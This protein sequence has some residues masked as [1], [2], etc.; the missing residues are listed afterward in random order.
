MRLWRALAPLLALA[1]VAGGI[2]SVAPRV[3]TLANWNAGVGPMLVSAWA[4]AALFAAAA[5]STGARLVRAA[6][7]GRPVDGFWALSFATGAAIFALAH[8][9]GGWVGALGWAWF[10]LLPLA[11][12]AWGWRTVVEVLVGRHEDAPWKLELSLLE[13]VALAFGVVCIGLL[14]LQTITADNVNYDAA[15]YH[16]RAAE[17]YALAGGQVHTPEGD[18]LLS[19]PQTASW[20]YTWA[21]LW[22][23]ASLEDHVRLAFLLELATVLGTLAALPALVRAVCPS[24]PRALTRLSWVAFFFYPS[25]FVYDTGVMGGADH[26]VTLW[27]VTAILAWLHA[28]EAGTL[29]AWALFGVHLAGL[30]AKYSSLYV[31]VP[32]T[33]LVAG[34]WLWR[35]LSARERGRVG[36][37]T[38][39]GPLVTAGLALALTSPY[40][41]RNAI[42][43]HN[44]VYPAATGIFP[45]TP[46]HADAEAWLQNSKESTFWTENGT[47]AHKLQVSAQALFNYQTELNTWGDL[48]QGQPVVGSS[49]FL[50][51]LALPFIRDRKRRLVMLAFIVNAG[52]FV[53]FNTH[54]HQFRYLTILMAP[55]AAGAAAVA[56]SLWRSESLFARAAVLA[57][58]AWHLAAFADMPFRKTHRMANRESTVSVA[59]EYLNRHG[60]RVGR[61]AAWEAI[62]QALPPSAVPL[63]HGSFPHLGL[64]RQSATDVTG[65]QFGINYGR[66][67]SQKEIHAQLRKMGVTHLIWNPGCEQSDSV[68]GEALFLGLATQVTEKKALHGYSVG[69]LPQEPREIGEGILYVG[70]ANLFESGLYTLE[71]LKVPVPPWFHPWPKVQPVAKVQGDWRALLPRASY[72]ALEAD[73]NLG[74]PPVTEFTWMND[75]MGFPRKL[76]HFVRTAGQAQGWGPPQ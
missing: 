9:L 74:D 20:L 70:C 10:V 50:S 60:G 29:R 59:S 24:L 5:L 11:M 4:L 38:A 23:R 33:L 75:Q 8:G 47:T 72:V 66:W 2:A 61:L 13:L 41:L 26:V 73:C 39:L 35:A 34:D 7:R 68:T 40:W 12:L 53:W 65:L 28:R 18:L 52:I 54:Q 55:M 48:T 56:L 63:V 42:W 19:L 21:F 67:G 71:A 44:P 27:A 45:S 62:G 31:L 32:L 25:I 69:E 43:F 37:A 16:L 1:A 14:F 58:A 15:W 46:W 36:R 57:A 51:L 49:Y 17:R 64:G 22:P 30:L 3:Y 76:R 6:F